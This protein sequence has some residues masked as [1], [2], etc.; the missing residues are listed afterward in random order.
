LITTASRT[1]Y[2]QAR[3]KLGIKKWRAKQTFVSS[4][5]VKKVI[6]QAVDDEHRVKCE[7]AKKLRSLLGHQ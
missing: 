6:D 7:D 4:L 1:A 2:G 3:S 5:V